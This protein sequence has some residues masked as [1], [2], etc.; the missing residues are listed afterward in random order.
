M[1]VKI[2]T[3]GDLEKN[4]KM[5]DIIQDICPN[6]DPHTALFIPNI[7]P[8]LIGLLSSQ[9]TVNTKDIEL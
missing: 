3:K 4:K 6:P 5:A 8:F 7:S 1:Y 9:K 2:S